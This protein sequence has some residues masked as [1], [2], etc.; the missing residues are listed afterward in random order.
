VIETGLANLTE[1]NTRVWVHRPDSHSQTWLIT[2][3]APGAE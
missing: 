3:I 2:R 1:A